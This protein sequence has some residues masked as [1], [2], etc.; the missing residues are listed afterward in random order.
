LNTKT[1]DSAVAR[2]KWL[3]EFYAPWC[4]HCKQLAPVFEEVARHFKKE[5]VNIRV[6]KVDCEA[7]ATVCASQ[8]VEG[9]PTIKYFHGG[10]GRLYKGG[11]RKTDFVDYVAKMARPPVNSV[12]KDEL[13]TLVSKW[14]SVAFVLVAGQS[15]TASIRKTFADVA[16]AVMDIDSPPFLE[17]NQTEDANSILFPDAEQNWPAIVLIRDTDISV[18]TGG[19]DKAALQEWVLQ[20]QFPYVPFGNELN[21]DVLSSGE[22]V[23]A[24]FDPTK[25]AEV[26]KLAEKMRIAYKKHAAKKDGLRFILLDA[27]KFEKFIANYGIQQKD[28]PVVFQLDLE[29]EIHYIDPSAKYNSV[30]SIL[31]LV[32]KV[33]SGSLK[34]QTWSSS[35]YWSAKVRKHTKGVGLFLYDNIWFVAAALGILGALF[36]FAIVSLLKEEPKAASKKD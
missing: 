23:V 31:N 36:V 4:G 11:R 17:F 22:I 35:A 1:F 3:V 8:N 27:H 13:K 24:A 26:S 6:A 29:N 20:N 7:H 12:T 10:T 18:F 16:Q 19:D 30:E 21:F 5:L 15:E 33:K 32:D 34:P 14:D 28:L 2:G 9:Y 25:T